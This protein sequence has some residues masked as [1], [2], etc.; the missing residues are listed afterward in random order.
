[1]AYLN[2][3]SCLGCRRFR[4]NIPHFKMLHLVLIL[5]ASFGPMSPAVG[6]AMP[7][8]ARLLLLVR[9]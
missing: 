1:M 9:R 5:P 6:L 8:S 2:K 7:V 4:V 3:L